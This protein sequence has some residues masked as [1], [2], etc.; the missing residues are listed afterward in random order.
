MRFLVF[1][2]RQL[3][4]RLE[5]RG[6]EII[7]LFVIC[8]TKELYIAIGYGRIQEAEGHP[9]EGADR[10]IERKVVAQTARQCDH[11]STSAGEY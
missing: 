10:R 4:L 8:G 9:S 11:F 7:C 3:L 1:Q 5:G 6:H 2:I